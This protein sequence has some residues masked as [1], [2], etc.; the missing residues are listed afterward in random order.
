MN[1]WKSVVAFRSPENVSRVRLQKQDGDR[2]NARGE[3]FVGVAQPTVPNNTPFYPLI[4]FVCRFEF[5]PIP[6]PSPHRDLHI[7]EVF[8]CSQQNSMTG[9]K[10]RGRVCVGGGGGWLSLSWLLVV[11]LSTNKSPVVSVVWTNNIPSDLNPKTALK[12]VLEVI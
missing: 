11:F 12:M 6:P 9:R 3:G 2:Q 5:A 10:Q 8:P 7:V 4:P 1:S